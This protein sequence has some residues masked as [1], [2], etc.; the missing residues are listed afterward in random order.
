[1]KQ[2]LV[3]L[4]GG[5]DSIT[6]LF[7]AISNGYNCSALTFDYDQLHNIE[8]ES[9]KKAAQIAGIKNHEISTIG[10]LFS[11]NSP[12]TNKSIEL[13]QYSNL[14]DVS[15]GIQKTFVPGRNLLF[16]SLAANKAY[17]MNIDTMITGICQEDFGGYPDCRQD[18]IDSMETTIGLALERE[19]EILAPLMSMKKFEIVK[20][21]K[22]LDETCWKALAYTHTSYDG[23]Y[24]PSSKDH[25]NMLRSKAF[26]E[27]N[28]PDPL[29][30]RAVSEKLIPLPK[31][32]NYETKNK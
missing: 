16:L 2:A 9:A 15:P 8:I 28:L 32:K 22:S 24:P 29:V 18:F 12:L 21:A 25:A 5:Q 20:L 10:P 27:A 1:M 6:C 3:I 19:I 7:W 4:S 17:S 11:G 13:E 23:K 26:E 14:A 30:L 31:S